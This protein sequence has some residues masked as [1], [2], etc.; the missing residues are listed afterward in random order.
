MLGAVENRFVVRALALTLSAKITGL[1]AAGDRI[2]LF[3]VSENVYKRFRCLEPS[4]SSC[5]D[6][7]ADG[8]GA[9]AIFVGVELDGVVVGVTSLVVRVNPRRAGGLNSYGRIDLVIVE[10]EFRSLRL[11][12]LLVTAALLHLLDT[13]GSRLYSV[14]CLA[15]H[16][17][18][19]RILATLGFARSERENKNYVHEELKL[20]QVDRLALIDDL[21]EKM[22]DVL[23]QTRF[24]LRQ[25]LGRALG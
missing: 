14:S 20:E 24:R 4:L 3:L 23:R 11:G 19:E 21:G 15:A 5:L 13:C 8:S 22:A 25:S 7:L 12:H 9:R 17:A 18:M 2:G 16:P 10:P 6:E 1:L